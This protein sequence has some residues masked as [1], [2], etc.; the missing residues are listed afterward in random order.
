MSERRTSRE[1][2]LTLAYQ[3]AAVVAEF[4]QRALTHTNLTMLLN[5]AVILLAR[6]LHVEFTEVLELLAEGS[7]PE[8]SVLVLKAGTGWSEGDVGHVTVSSGTDSPAGYALASREPVVVEDLRKEVRF[9][10]PALLRKHGIVSGMSL[11]IE[12][13]ERPYGVLGVHTVK[14]REF[15]ENDTNFLQ[16]IATVLGMA[17]ERQRIEEELKKSEERFEATFEQAAV[18]IGHV[19]LEGNW[20]RVNSKL[21]EILGYTRE[22]LL[23]KTSQDIT[24]PKDLEKDLEQARRLLSGTTGTYSTEKRYFRKDGS[25]VWVNFT[26]SLVRDSS[27]KPAYLNAAIENLHESKRARES[28]LRLRE[29]AITAS[30]NSI[31]IT[32]P[33]QPDNPIVYV[34]PAFEQTTGYRAD[35]AVGRN[36]RFLQSDDREQSALK[37]LKTALHEGQHCTVVLRNYRKDGTRFWNELSV[38][39]V[40]DE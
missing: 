18:G 39:P 15:T 31:V 4:G 9:S 33:T 7:V 17:I 10:E 36:C 2:A 38:Y 25:V 19:A 11:I 12:G 14:R 24:H 6:T 40:R 20:L 34:N 1:T 26:G 35:E 16:A 27:G 32:D 37:D 13:R 23:E 22:E 28:L 8:A 29:R 30:T 5:D 3:Q 21:C